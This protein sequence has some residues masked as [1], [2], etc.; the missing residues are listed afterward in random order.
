MAN[1]YAQFVEEKR[2]ENPYSQFVSSETE[3]T[4]EQLDKYVPIPG[5]V[6]EKSAVPM[7]TKRNIMEGYVRPSLELTGLL[8]GGAIG[9]TA[10]GGTPASAVLGVA[11]ASLGYTGASQIA[12]RLDEFFGLAE[13]EGLLETTKQTGKQLETGAKLE[14]GGQVAGKAIGLTGTG[15]NKLAEKTGLKDFFNKIKTAF[16]TLSDRGVLLKAKEYLTNIRETTPEIKRTSELIEQETEA[17]L[18]RGKIK[19]EPTYA[20]K[21]GNI[22][23]ANYEQS[24][25][26]K[27][28]TTKGELALRDAKINK[29][30]LNYVDRTFAGEGS[31]DDII[32]VVGAE[33]KALE[34]TA[35]G[36]A[37][38]TKDVVNKL[39]LGETVQEVGQTA[40]SVLATKKGAVSR[41]MKRLF[42]EIPQNISL[43][44]DPLIKSI[45]GVI[46]D[47]K[48]KGGSPDSLP[49]SIMN[50]MKEEKNL[51][52]G[53]LRGYRSTVSEMIR[54]NSK[55]MNPNLQLVRRLKMLRDGID[56][57]LGQMANNEN[58]I[59]ADKYKEALS[60]YTDFVTKYRKGTVGEIL[61]YGN[62]SSGYAVTSD[63]VPQ[64]FFSSGRMDAAD[65]LIAAVGKEEASILVEDFAEQQF[66]S[67]SL[68]DGVLNSELGRKWISDNKVILKKYD[69]LN[70]FKEIVKTGEVSEQ[71]LA[72]LNSY[73]KEV[74]SRILN[75]DVDKVVEKIFTG[76]GKTSSRRTMKELLNSRG[77]KNNEQAILGLQNAF[78]DFYLNKIENNG[79]NLLG[80]PIRSAAKANKILKELEPAMEV[81]YKDS[82]KKLQALKDY[83]KFLEML[84][85][86]KQVAF[87]SNTA[88]KILG[89]DFG[90]YKSV[91]ANFAQAAAVMKGVGW[92]YSSLKNLAG[93]TVGLIGKIPQDKIDALLIEAIYNP[94]IAETI[95][96]ASKT[97]YTKK[98]ERTLIQQ[99]VKTGLYAREKTKESE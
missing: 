34:G 56:D 62:Q 38:T 17:L 11:G 49:S 21:T 35:I 61:Q 39:G 99:L 1:P 36:T 12:D 32:S 73:N 89:S 46:K 68:K 60:K 98:L 52:F 96:R 88:D 40:Q 85:R 28:P 67:K 97:G 90:T 18:K 74:A 19:T 83:H 71:A 75:T 24:I 79:I 65:D 50:L 91:A 43:K 64:R 7:E 57:T 92:F 95:M 27:R 14:M 10:G 13:N 69:L 33:Q 86:N 41:E 58:K 20:Q 78:K 55:G 15:L 59:Y 5:P 84:D 3:P 54:D 80:D 76:V 16:P 25:M 6:F 45:K 63:Q 9:T 22:S 26:S 70:K 29:E 51:T 72:K 66:L 47:H 31:I 44:K 2:T 82:P 53:K 23:A 37:K 30:A 87:G 42:D 4:Q 77:I 8:G 48:L 93:A 81:L 94:E